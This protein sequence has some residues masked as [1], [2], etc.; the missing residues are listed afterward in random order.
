MSEPVAIPDGFA[1]HDRRSPVTDPWEPLYARRRDGVVE[2]GL[3]VGAAH[4]NSRGFAHGG[5]LASLA[6]NAMGL[7]Y[8]AARL[9]ADPEATTGAGA[10]TVSLTIDYIATARIGQWLQIT[11]RV[12]RAGSAMGFV[13]ALLTADGAGVARASATFRRL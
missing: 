13:E 7:S 10:V 4:C 6:D 8:H 5:V 2:L 12:L 1:R 9:L 3:V 11:P